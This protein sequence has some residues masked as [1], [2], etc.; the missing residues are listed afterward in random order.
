M[1]A[2]DE[3]QKTPSEFFEFAL[4]AGWTSGA[5]G[6]AT[7]PTVDLMQRPFTIAIVTEGCAT[8]ITPGVQ[9]GLAIGTTAAGAL[10]HLNNPLL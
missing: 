5:G 10:W 1:H 2:N 3:T 4:P 9:R 6:P 8:G 7:A